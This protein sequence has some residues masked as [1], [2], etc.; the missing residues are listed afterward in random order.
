LSKKGYREGNP[1]GPKGQ[2]LFS[3]KTAKIPTKAFD[4]LSPVEEFAVPGF[5]ADCRLLIFALTKIIVTFA[6]LII[7]EII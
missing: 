5:Q 1:F 2:D 3:R 4:N 7:F 6:A